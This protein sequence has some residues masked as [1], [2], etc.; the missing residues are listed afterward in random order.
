MRG[1]RELPGLMRQ[2]GLRELRELT[3]LMGWAEGA[4]GADA[5]ADE[6]EGS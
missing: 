6:V 2:E 4:A 3:G 5:G 1:L